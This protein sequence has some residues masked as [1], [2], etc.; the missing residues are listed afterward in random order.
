MEEPHPISPMPKPFPS[1]PDQVTNTWLSQVLGCQVDGF[2]IQHF[3]E[4]AGIIGQVVR[5]NLDS[6]AP[7]ESLVAKFPS[8]SEGNR[9]VAKTYNMY[10]REIGFYQHIASRINVRTPKCYF[11]EFDEA[12]NDFVLLIEDL[13]AYEIGDQVK[14]CSLDQARMVIS[15]VAKLHASAWQPTTEFGLV[16]HNNPAQRDGMIAGFDMGWS[17]VMEGF[18]DLV[19]NAALI[20]EKKMASATPWLLEEM[21]RPPVCL[22]HADVRLDNLFFGETE[23]CLV[24]WQS[25]CTSC[26]EQD[27]AYFLTQSIALEMVGSADLKG[28][29]FQELRAQGIDYPRR[30]FEERYKIAALYLLNYAVIIAGTLDLGNERGQALGRTLLGGSFASLDAL[31]AFELLK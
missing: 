17:A 18:R 31:G 19:P 20:A 6:D 21:A 13:K 25:V 15:D 4:G 22:T 29:Y 12:S 8:A 11:G 16:S 27:I 1:S 5:I 2:D 7:F 28:L 30:Q 10:G 26:P 23:I 24:D 3:A 9:L 14:G